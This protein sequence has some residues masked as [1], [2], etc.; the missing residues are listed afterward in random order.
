MFELCM[1]VYM[2]FFFF[3]SF[4]CVCVCVCTDLIMSAQNVGS[5]GGHQAFR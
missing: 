5:R 3:L 1:R 2:F 4:F